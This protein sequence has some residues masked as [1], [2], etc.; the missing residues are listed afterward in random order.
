MI[1]PMGKCDDPQLDAS[2]SVEFDNMNPP[3][4]PLFR[5]IILTGSG[6]A[7]PPGTFIAPGVP[8]PP[9]NALVHA[10][11]LQCDQ[12]SA[13]TQ[14]RNG[15]NAGDNTSR[16]FNKLSSNNRMAGFLCRGRPLVARLLSPA[17]SSGP[18][19]N[20]HSHGS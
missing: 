6:R 3:R 15:E 13:N 2:V 1:V 8:Q 17:A 12:A 14:N 9:F 16:W 18:L 4:H 10:H 11:S 5:P 20:F 19:V 7:S